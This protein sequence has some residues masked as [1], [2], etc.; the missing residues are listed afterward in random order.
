MFVAM[1]RRP[2]HHQSQFFVHSSVA[3]HPVTNNEELGTTWHQDCTFSPRSA[4]QVN[5]FVT[6]TAY[7]DKVRPHPTPHIA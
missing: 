6:I 5:V 4:R 2:D 3:G 7:A 1:P